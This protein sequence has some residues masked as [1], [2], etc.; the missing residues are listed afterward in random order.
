MSTLP[1]AH[2]ETRTRYAAMEKGAGAALV[3]LSLVAIACALLFPP[4][5]WFTAGS[6]LAGILT[7]WCWRAM[8]AS[9][10]GFGAAAAVAAVVAALLALTSVLTLP[11]P[12][13]LA[14][15][16]SH[17]GVGLYAALLLRRL[18]TGRAGHEV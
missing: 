12:V 13:V 16:L 18:L 6:L 2:D 8:L 5:F 4:G 14:M 10:P 9:K 11:L 17:L 7:Y 3:V 15:G 1:S